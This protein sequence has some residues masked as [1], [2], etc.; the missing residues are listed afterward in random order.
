MFWT[1]VSQKET[2]SSFCLWS[3]G[4]TTKSVKKLLYNYLNGNKAFKN[5]SKDKNIH[6]NTIKQIKPY[7]DENLWPAIINDCITKVCMYHQD[8]IQVHK[9]CAFVKLFL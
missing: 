7:Q 8:S 6:Y 3:I 4:Q 9:N 1:V 2:I 5:K